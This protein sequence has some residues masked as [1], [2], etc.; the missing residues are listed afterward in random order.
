MLIGNIPASCKKSR[1]VREHEAGLHLLSYG[2]ELLGLPIQA[3]YYN[4]YEKPYFKG[5][6]SPYFSISH[7]SNH[8]ACAISRTEIGCDIEKIKSV[9]HILDKELD[10]IRYINK[11]T[12]EICETNRTILWTIYESIAKCIGKGIPVHQEDIDTFAWNVK[13][14]MIKKKYVLSIAT[15]IMAVEYDTNK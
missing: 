4:K 8:V 5:F 10:K 3:F 12:D 14:W 9:P 2:M 1:E 7:S 6:G 11:S 15:R 13:T